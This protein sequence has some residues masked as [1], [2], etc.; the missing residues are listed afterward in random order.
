MVWPE[1]C[2]L[3]IVDPLFK[4]RVPDLRAYVLNNLA[5]QPSWNNGPIPAT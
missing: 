1:D 3:S 5:V 4:P 2:H